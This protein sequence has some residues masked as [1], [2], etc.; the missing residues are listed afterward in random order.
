M[1]SSRVKKRERNSLK[2]VLKDFADE[3]S[4]DGLKFI[5]DE[6]SSMG[7]RLFLYFL[8]KILLLHQEIRCICAQ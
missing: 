6:E 7:E 5:A 2:A 4:M 3:T 8:L 1:D